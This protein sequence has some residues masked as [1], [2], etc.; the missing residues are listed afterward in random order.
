M[1]LRH[2][3]YFV[4]VADYGH[5][6]RAAQVLHVAQ[7][8]VSQ[9]LRQFERE[10][11]VTL[12]ERSNRGMR[13]TEVGQRLLPD[14]R[15]ALAH[16][17]GLVDRAMQVAR[18]HMGAVHVGYLPLLTDGL[19]TAALRILRGRRPQVDVVLH[20]VAF[21]DRLEVLRTRRADVVLVTLP[22]DEAEVVCG[23]V[24]HRGRRVLAVPAGH[25]L[26]ERAP[27]GPEDLAGQTVASPG[28]PVVPPWMEFW[29]PSATPAGSPIK[30]GPVVATIGELLTTVATSQVVALLPSE[31][32]RVYGRKEISFLDIDVE[33]YE[34][35]P[36]WSP[37]SHV[38]LIETFVEALLEA[39][40]TD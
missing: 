16:A 7:P 33:G 9:A 18:G 5:M 25:P 30:R 14:A 28:A 32:A 12:F 20:E 40:D 35:V 22:C 2:L 15:A 37:D 8:A 6:T 27:L 38:P 34:I 3:R 19:V 29:R 39:G 36:V 10:L 11:G 24:V 1:E 17:Q 4:A 26:E 23:P 21:L 13:L 31:V